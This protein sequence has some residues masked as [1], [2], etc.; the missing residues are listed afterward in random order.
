MSGSTGVSIIILSSASTLGVALLFK[1]ILIFSKVASSCSISPTSS[2]IIL[3]LSSVIMLSPDVAFSN[4]IEPPTI[5]TFASAP[6]PSV[7]LLSN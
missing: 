3:S 2:T 6:V 1:T 4:C 5:S 7:S